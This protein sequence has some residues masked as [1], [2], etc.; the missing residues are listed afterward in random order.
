MTSDAVPFVESDAPPP[1]G[2]LTRLR[3]GAGDWLRDATLWPLAVPYLLLRS[4]S[5]IGAT[6]MILPDSAT[7]RQ[8]PSLPPYTFVSLTGEAMRGWVVPLFFAVLPSDMWR[9][10]AQFVVSLV[11][12]LVLAT[13][14]SRTLTVPVLR[15]ASFVAILVLSC[16]A[17]VASWDRAILADSLSISLTALTFASWVVFVQ[18][19]TRGASIAVIAMTTLWLFTKPTLFAE[20]AIAAVVLLVFAALYRR[21]RLTYAVVGV[22]L[23]LGAAWGGV[24]GAASDTAFARYPAY[25]SFGQNGL[26]Q[27]GQNF[28][29]A[30]RLEILGDPQARAWFIAE[31]MPNPT[32]LTPY[33]RRNPTDDDFQGQIAFTNRLQQRRDLVT[34]IEG[35][36]RSVW[37]R[38][39]LTHFPE[40]VLQ[41]GIDLPW[42]LVPPRD[43]FVYVTQYRSVLPDSIESLVFDTGAN[44]FQ[45]SSTYGD[46]GLWGGA[47]IALAIVGRFRGANRPVLIVAVG[48]GLIAVLGIGASW[49]ASPVE[50]GRHALPNSVLVRI[51]LQV[52]AFGLANAWMTRSERRPDTY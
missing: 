11:A 51:A 29:S 8:E 46:I 36:G 18:R 33:T 3:R 39:V 1:P 44:R 22:V 52:V 26:S 2:A 27:F 47:I 7:W 34:W 30:L 43:S 48:A 45:L 35:D 17:A 37:F 16:T 6:P 19:P 41:F 32:G 13:V 4:L 21:H 24:S 12:W 49:I 38:Y 25:R 50:L 28:M 10:V 31:G 20:A 15:W 5:M 42:M 14:V 40:K 23:V 9:M